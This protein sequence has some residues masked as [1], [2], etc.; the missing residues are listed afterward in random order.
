[1]VFYRL[2]ECDT[3]TFSF[4]SLQILIRKPFLEEYHISI[5]IE[6]VIIT[7]NNE[8]WLVR[9]VAYEVGMLN[10][11]QDSHPDQRIDEDFCRSEMERRTS[12]SE[13]KLKKHCEAW[14]A[15]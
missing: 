14:E 1:M 12:S 15:R 10:S 6:T 11:I 7:W 5:C 2:P 4:I 9:R 8:I 13:V 3:T